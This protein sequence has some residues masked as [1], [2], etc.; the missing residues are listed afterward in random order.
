MFEV[1]HSTNAPQPI[2]PYSQAVRAGQTVYLSGQI[3]LDPEHGELAPGGLEAQARRA[4]ANL[5]AVAEASGGSLQQVVR[6]TIYMTDLA[7]FPTVNAI[8]EEL[9]QPPYPARATLGVASLPKG[10][11]FEVDA[12][13]VLPTSRTGMG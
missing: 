13:L 10:A 11:L 7:H 2:G 1:I 4:L 8:M 12:V 6:L 3:G 5:A 9:W